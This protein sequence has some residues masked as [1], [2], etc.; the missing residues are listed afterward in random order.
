VMIDELEMVQKKRKISARVA[1]VSGEIRTWHPPNTNLDCY[2]YVI[3]NCF[4]TWYTVALQPSYQALHCD[5]I[6]IFFF[7][8]L[9]CGETESTWY[10]CHYFACCTSPGW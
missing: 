4:H 10:V 8:F 1:G 5:S 7:S 6:L 3:G 9:G 2:R